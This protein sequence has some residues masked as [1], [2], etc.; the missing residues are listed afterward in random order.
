M[1][2]INIQLRVK[3]LFDRELLRNIIGAVRSV[4]EKCQNNFHESVYFSND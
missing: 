1:L 4:Y 2:K 3:V